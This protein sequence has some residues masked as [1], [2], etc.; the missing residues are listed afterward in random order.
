MG[1]TMSSLLTCRILLLQCAEPLI[2]DS[3]NLAA[4]YLLLSVVSAEALLDIML[5]EWWGNDESY[6]GLRGSSGN[7]DRL[8]MRLHQFH[9]PGDGTS[10][11]LAFQSGPLR[12]SLISSP[13]SSND[14]VLRSRRMSAFMAWKASAWPRRAVNP[15]R[16]AAVAPKAQ[17]VDG[18]GARRA[19]ILLAMICLMI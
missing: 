12:F 13:Y 2:S 17:G 19:I 7:D 10:G 15:Q 1:P 16:R 14:G 8:N 5:S 6:L 11:A 4:E 9:R 18:E 3:P